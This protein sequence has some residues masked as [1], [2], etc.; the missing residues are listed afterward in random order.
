MI[1]SP[2]D[3]RLAVSAPS[4]LVARRRQRRQRPQASFVGDPVAVKLE[5]ILRHYHRGTSAVAAL[6]EAQ[7]SFASWMQNSRTASR[8]ETALTMLET[9]LAFDAAQDEGRVIELFRRSEIGIGRH[10]VRVRRDVLFF[11]LSGH[12]LRNLSWTRDGLSP[13]ELRL[14]LCPVVLSCDQ[15]LGVDRLSELEYWHLRS[16]TVTSLNLAAARRAAHALA[17]LLDDA[18]GH[19]AEEGLDH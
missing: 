17:S 6:Q 10:V 18:E 7:Q 1:F 13:S 12:R 5:S 3:V 9:Y 16:E 8:A 19:L 11:G 4:T 14:L 2:S 15:D